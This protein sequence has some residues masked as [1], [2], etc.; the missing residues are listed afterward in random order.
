M[1]LFSSLSKPQTLELNFEKNSIADYG[2][3]NLGSILENYS[4]IQ[5]L[6]LNLANNRIRD[7]LGQGLELAFRNMTKLSSI[8]LDLTGNYIAELDVQ[9]QG[10][11]VIELFQSPKF[12][13]CVLVNELYNNQVLKLV[14]QKIQSNQCRRSNQIGTQGASRLAF[15]FEK[16]T[17]IQ[18]LTLQLDENNMDDE[19]IRDLSLGLKNCTNIQFI[20]LNVRSNQFSRNGAIL[21]DYT[22]LKILRCDLSCN[23]IGDKSVK[24][25]GSGLRN[26]Y[27]KIQVL[28]LKNANIYQI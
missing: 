15:A 7:S 27:Q 20:C 16:Q 19:A 25:F 5:F 11:W 3:T 9:G 21:L 8:D 6:K 17:N 13:S 4:N 23:Q 28:V 1:C 10:S 2:I 26:Q 18:S 22:Q 12:E 14:Y 24:G